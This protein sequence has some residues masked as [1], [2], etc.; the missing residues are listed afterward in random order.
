V[1]GLAV[2]QE[3]H[4][5]VGRTALLPALC[6]TPQAQVEDP[7]FLAQPAASDCD[8]LV[9]HFRDAKP[10]AHAAEICGNLARLVREG[11][12]LVLIHGASGA[13][14]GRADYR[15]MAGGT[16]GPNY[17]HDAKAIDMPCTS[18]LLRRGCLWAAAR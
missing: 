16:W 10:L 1:V 17:G 7:E 2:G 18:E 3:D 6:G 9:L 15:G 14:P 4:D 8:V 5:L 12:G 11:R 13:F